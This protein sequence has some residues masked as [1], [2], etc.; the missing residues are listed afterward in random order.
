LFVLFLDTSH[1][2]WGASLNVKSPLIQGLNQMI[3]GDDLVAIMT[4]GMES[5]DLTFSRRTTAIEEFLK[6]AWGR[7]DFDVKPDPEEEYLKLCFGPDNADD[8]LSRQL[9]R[10]LREVR[11]FDALQ[12]LVQHLRFVR[13]ERKAVIAITQGWILYGDDPMLR[14]AMDAAPPIPPFGLDPRTGRLGRP[15]TGGGSD[16]YAELREKCAQLRIS[17]SM[18][19]NEQ[20]FHS[21]LREAN[22]G[23]TSFYPMDPRGLVVFEE[24]IDAKVSLIEDARRLKTRTESLHMMADVTDGLAVVQ[25]GNLHAGMQ[26]I[27]EDVSSYYLIGYYSTTE[28]DGKFHRLTV[29]VKRPGVRVRARTGYLAATR[30]D[31]EKARAAAAAAGLVKPVDLQAQAVEQALSALAIFSRERPLRVQVAATYRR[32]GDAVIHAVAEVPATG[33]RHDWIDGGQAEATLVNGNGQTVAT[34]KLAIAPGVR[35]IR[36]A[37]GGQAALAP[38][39]YQLRIRAKGTSAPLSALESVRVTLPAVP[40]GTGAMVTRRGVTTGNQPMPT[41]DLRFRRTERIVVEVPATSADA[42]TARL[43][44]RSGKPMAIPVTAAIRE[45]ADGSRWRTAQVALA[46]LAIGDYVIEMSAGEEQTLTA[47]RVLP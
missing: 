11:T 42:G 19:Q 3:G 36:L 2:N 9:I 37:I 26:R 17:L 20:R 28:M 14:A 31:H 40:V 23:N 4:P 7:R 8:S 21:I 44:E 32:S 30:A 5:R 12:Q 43:L 6:T 10:R 29:R 45:D 34:Q 13:E 16:S 15:V 38:G 24:D 18:L 33:A 25:T 41:A 1:V 35:S 46:P 22:T 47:I 39:D 27:V